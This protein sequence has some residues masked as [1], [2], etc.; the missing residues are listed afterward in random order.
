MSYFICTRDHYVQ[1]HR[2]EHLSAGDTC[3][4]RDC[5]GHLRPAPE[6]DLEADRCKHC[7]RGVKVRTEVDGVD[8]NVCSYCAATTRIVQSDVPAAPRAMTGT[9]RVAKHRAAKRAQA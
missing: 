7:N 2:G 5:S 9:E 1:Q 6:G 4:A 3:P 8:S